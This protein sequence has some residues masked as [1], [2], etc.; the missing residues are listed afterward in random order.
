MK[1]FFNRSGK[2]RLWGAALMCFLFAFSGAML[3]ADLYRALMCYLGSPTDNVFA[4]VFIC[5]LV[6]MYFNVAKM[7][8]Q[9]Y[10]HK[11]QQA[12]KKTPSKRRSLFKSI[13]LK[14]PYYFVCTL[15][16]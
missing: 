14:L 15:H 7:Q 8:L 1:N 11:E 16:A 5:L 3:L 4:Y 2:F 6:P 9:L 10:L 12:E 13:V